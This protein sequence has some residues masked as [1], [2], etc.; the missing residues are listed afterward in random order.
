MLAELENRR[1]QALL[2]SQPEDPVSLSGYGGD[3][4]FGGYNRYFW[5]QSADLYTF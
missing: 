5:G 1:S 3:E 4:L 2:K